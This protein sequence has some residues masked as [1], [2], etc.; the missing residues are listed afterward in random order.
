MTK[1][2]P[3]APARLSRLM[4]GIGIIAALGMLYILHQ[5]SIA[6]NKMV[7]VS[8]IALI[9]GAIIEIKRLTPKWS[10]VIGIVLFSLL[11]SSISF[12]PGKHENVY[13]WGIHLKIWPYAFLFIFLIFAYAIHKD[14]II[15]RMTEG[16]TLILSVGFLYWLV[17]H[18][19]YVTKSAVQKAFVIVGFVVAIF[20]IINAFVNIK[21]SPSLRLSL[22]I[23]SSIIMILL[24]V[25][26][27][28]GVYQQG[29]VED[30]VYLADKVYIGL[31]YFLLGTSSIY[32]FQNFMMIALFLPD[33]YRFFNAE[34]FNDVRI[35]KREHINRYSENQSGMKLSFIG[36]V[37][38]SGFFLSNY[39]LEFLPTNTAI[40]LVFFILNSI[41]YY[42]EYKNIAGYFNKKTSK[43]TR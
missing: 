33:K 2:K 13:D 38:S 1:Q 32:I 9:T 7:P 23:W 27:I 10:T 4:L 8:V 18:D 6:T 31:Q 25:D 28:Y 5:L 22:S 42:Y 15:P 16:I 37:V 21:L 3:S 11:L 30:S 34:Y 17:D 12:M 26:N 40:W 19:F 29:A 24:A 39:L 41:V 36:L 43:R 20:S 35:L 14:K